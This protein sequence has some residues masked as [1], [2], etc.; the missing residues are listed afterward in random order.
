MAAASSAN[1][2]A[3]APPDDLTDVMWS[4][5]QWLATFPLNESTALHYFSLSQ[6]YDSSCNNELINMQRLDISLLSTMAGIEYAV[7]SPCSGLFIVQKRRRSLNPPKLSLLSSYYIYDGCVYQVPSLHAVLSTR[8]LQAIHHV[9]NA[10]EA[11]HSA[12]AFSSHGTHVWDPSPIP[13]DDPLTADGPELTAGERN[14]VDD[15]LYDIWKKNDAIAV[16]NAEK[17]QHSQTQ[18]EQSAP[19]QNSTSSGP[20]QS[21]QGPA[22]TTASDIAP[23]R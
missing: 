9:K 5:P 7:S 19:L 22:T 10:F 8:V 6:F 21:T 20:L 4:D 3:Q 11:M 18:A 12:A 23:N 17:L 2:M 13:V 15:M 16:Q 1:T 14:A